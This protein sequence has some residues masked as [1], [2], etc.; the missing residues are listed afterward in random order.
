[1]ARQIETGQRLRDDLNF[2]A[3]R[4][5]KL[6]ERLEHAVRSARMFG[7][8]LAFAPNPPAPA[9]PVMPEP[10]PESVPAPVL[11][12]QAERELMRAL[13]TAR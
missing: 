3:E 9:A 6:A 8:G 2:L 5:D 13:R 7:D 1:M 4:S 10:L 12:S 11:R